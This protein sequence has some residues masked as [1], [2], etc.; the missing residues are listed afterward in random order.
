[1]LFSWGQRRNLSLVGAEKRVNRISF[2]PLFRD[3]QSEKTTNTGDNLRRCFRTAVR[4][5]YRGQPS[6]D[7]G[8]WE[9]AGFVHSTRFWH[10][11]SQ[12]VTQ[13]LKIPCLTQRQLSVKLSWQ[14]DGENK[15]LAGFRGGLPLSRTAI[16][17]EHDIQHLRLRL[18]ESK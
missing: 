17:H 16:K 8:I 11:M 10:K 3:S 9:L 6:F 1:M 15:P 7:R 13:R 12:Q 14:G 4:L 2:L 5:V 18:K